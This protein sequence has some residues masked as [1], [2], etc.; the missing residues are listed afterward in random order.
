MAQPA[1][2]R[3]ERGGSV[4]IPLAAGGRTPGEV[5]FL[6]RT[7]P[8]HG[9]L[10][11][12]RNTSPKSA[13][14]D[15]THDGRRGTSVDE[16]RYAAQAVDSPVSAAAAVRVYI[17]EP[18]VR[19]GLAREISFAP[20]G[21]GA[22]SVLRI[23][24]SNVRGGDGRV[25]VDVDPP[26]VLPEGNSV[27]LPAGGRGEIAVGFRPPQ[28]GRFEGGLRIVGQAGAAALLDGT[29]VDVF[30]LSGGGALTAMADGRRAVEFSIRNPG[31]NPVEI[32]VAYPPGLTGPEAATL[33]PGEELRLTAAT[34]AGF[35]GPVSGGI[36][37]AAGPVRKTVPVDSEAAP[38]R[39]LADPAEL[40]FGGLRIGES[41]SMELRV[42]NSGGTAAVMDFAPPPGIRVS[43]DPAMSVIPPAGN[44][45]FH[46]EFNPISPGPFRD[47]LVFQPAKGS[48]PLMVPVE[49]SVAAPT[50]PRPAV[51]NPAAGRN[52]VV[53]QAPESGS[54][55]SEPPADGPPGPGSFEV[56]SAEPGRVVLAWPKSDAKNFFLEFRE[57]VPG[58]GDGPPAMRWHPWRFVNFTEA[59][60][61]T[62]ASIYRLPPGSLWFMRV[63]PADAAGRRGTPS[64]VF[65]LS[66]PEKPDRP[67]LGWLVGGAV[68]ILIAGAAW[69][70]FRKHRDDRRLA[71]ARRIANLE[72]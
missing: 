57:L 50:A 19:P 35:L 3:V 13:V 67:L 28:A 27:E 66:V 46:V 39:L 7:N 58:T 52:V 72:S 23:P 24:I 40:V 11:T 63:V 8:R 45:T 64:P 4:A 54:P 37:V 41:K 56:V 32:M 69:K 43:P 33:R 38:A 22:E 15:Y 18:P 60:G 26:W 62:R 65:R 47:K 44:R 10:G 70:I 61:S 48:P 29:G 71:E 2:V 16:F 9:T 51:P 36:E 59:D 1:T 49:A 25:E 42:K 34:A 6:I 17:E 55:P 12:P 20:T 30:T 31:K 68:A 21:V 5:R 14:V 53:V